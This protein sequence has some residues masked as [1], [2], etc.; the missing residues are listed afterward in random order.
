MYLWFNYLPKNENLECCVYYSMICRLNWLVYAVL[1]VN[2]WSTVLLLWWHTAIYFTWQS[3]LLWDKVCYLLCFHVLSR[4]NGFYLRGHGSVICQTKYFLWLPMCAH[5]VSVT[6]KSRFTKCQKAF[7]CSL[8]GGGANITW[9]HYCTVHFLFIQFQRVRNGMYPEPVQ[10]GGILG[11]SLSG[12]YNSKSW[13]LW[14]KL[15][16]KMAN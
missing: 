9:S 1:Y 13:H 4:F 8:R 3:K 5:Q 14:F 2:V 12:N 7:H 10:S 15:I 16:I 6:C 11:I